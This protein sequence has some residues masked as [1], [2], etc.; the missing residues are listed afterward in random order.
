MG[1]TNFLKRHHQTITL[2]SAAVVIAT[3]LIK[4]VL[5]EDTKQLVDELSG[6]QQ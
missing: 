2:A 6:A 5:R 3:F 1:L 4:D